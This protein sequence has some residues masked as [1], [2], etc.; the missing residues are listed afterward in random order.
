VVAVD[1]AAPNLFLIDTVSEQIRTVPL[2]GVPKAA[3]IARY[4]DDFSCS[5]SP[6]SIATP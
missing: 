4:S 5:A 1:D 2:E 6:A 3:Q